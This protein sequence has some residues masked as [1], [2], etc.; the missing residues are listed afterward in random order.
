[1]TIV[2]LRIDLGK[3]RCSLAGQDER[4]CVVPRSNPAQLAGPVSG[5]PSVGNHL[6]RDFPNNFR[7]EANLTHI[8]PP[9]E[10]Y[11]RR[12]CPPAGFWWF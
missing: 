4:D 10:L 12:D 8:P 2:T 9:L 6:W 1:M 5:S 7:I 3:T 11:S